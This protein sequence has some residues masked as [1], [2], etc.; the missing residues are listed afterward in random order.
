M[1]S[2]AEIFFIALQAFSSV[3][4]LL[5]IYESNILVYAS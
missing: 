3:L 1:C 5:H 4:I 2:H